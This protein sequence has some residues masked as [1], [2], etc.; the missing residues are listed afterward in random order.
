VPIATADEAL[1]F[2]YH[3]WARYDRDSWVS[4]LKENGFLD[5]M[6]G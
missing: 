5:R 1:P 6:A 4:V 2:A 3:A